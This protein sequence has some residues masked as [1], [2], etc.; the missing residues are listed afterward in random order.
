MLESDEM[1][2]TDTAIILAGGKSSRMGFDKQFLKIDE[3][4]LMNSIISKLQEEFKEIIIVT[5]RPEEYRNSN[6]KIKTDIIAGMGPLSGIHAGLTESSSRYSY[7]IACDMPNINLEYI[8]YMKTCI[9]DKEIDGCVSL[10]NDKVE[11]LN[12]F[13][14]KKIIKDIEKYLLNGKRSIQHLLKDLQIH[15]I[16]ESIVRKFSPNLDMFINL[17]TIEDID[18]FIK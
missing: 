11:P 10:V 5:N 8:R 18:F 6:H 15:Y 14:H 17:N 4:I 3:K 12:S 2:S 7:I 13:F 1:K 16:K 9:G